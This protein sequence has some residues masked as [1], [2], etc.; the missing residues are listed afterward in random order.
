MRRIIFVLTVS[1]FLFSGIIQGPICTLTSPLGYDYDGYLNALKLDTVAW[2]K[3]DK[4]TKTDKK[5]GQPGNPI[6]V[7]E[8][9]T[10]LLL[11]AALLGIVVLARKKF[12]RSN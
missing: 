8:P 11:G 12:N 3:K 9:S 7:P 1:V 5:N 2:A 4:K 10:T 6:A